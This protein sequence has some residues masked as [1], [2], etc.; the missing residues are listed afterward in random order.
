[1]RKAICMTLAA[2]TVAAALTG[3]SAM[4][5]TG[6]ND[7]RNV[8]TRRDGIVN[9]SERNSLLGEDGILDDIADKM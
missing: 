2:L 6:R 9:G 3:C 5:D 7:M 8:S 1:M 4:T